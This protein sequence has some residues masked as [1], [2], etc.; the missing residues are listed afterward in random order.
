MQFHLFNE[1]FSVKC[2]YVSE[3]KISMETWNIEG[4][5]DSDWM[6]NFQCNSV[7]RT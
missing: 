5:N 2:M 4:D 6:I 3:M 7:Q 1:I